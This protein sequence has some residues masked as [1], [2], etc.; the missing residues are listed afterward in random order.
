MGKMS[1]FCSARFGSAP[2]GLGHFSA[3]SFFRALP[4]SVYS[5]RWALAA[6]AF[7]FMVAA[8]LALGYERV[9][10]QGPT[11]GASVVRVEANAV[12]R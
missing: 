3:R 2:R 4:Q 8:L 7:S 6:A 12:Q 9:Q 11:H 5:V 10:S 1:L